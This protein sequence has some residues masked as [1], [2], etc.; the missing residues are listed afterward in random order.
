MK[1][2][3]GGLVYGHAAPRDTSVPPWQ[4]IHCDSIGN[5]VIDLRARTLKFHAMTIIDAWT[6]LVEIVYTYGT[7]AE[8]AAAAVEN[9]WLARYPRP[10]KVVTDQGPEFGQPFTDMCQ[11]N[12]CQHVSSTSRNPQG[13]S[14][15]ESSHKTISQVLRTVVAAK[16]PWFSFLGKSE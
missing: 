12:G 16:N 5:W 10:Y 13:N 2:K 11:N 3:R 14:L 6:N 4:Q 15:I 9:N 8:E 1:C 7:T